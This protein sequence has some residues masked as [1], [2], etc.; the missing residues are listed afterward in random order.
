MRR[1]LA[2]AL[3]GMILVAGVGALGAETV[4]ARDGPAATPAD[5][6][7]ESSSLGGGDASDVLVE[8]LEQLGVPST[9]DT[10]DESDGASGSNATE[11]SDADPETGPPADGNDTAGALDSDGDGLTDERER[12]LGTEVFDPDTDGDGLVDGREIDLN[13]DPL[14]PDTDGDGVSDARELER[15]T[16]PRSVDADAD[17]LTDERELELGTDP[18]DPD[19]DDDGLDDRRELELGTD[20]TVADTDGDRLL[21]GWEFREETPSG[22]ALPDSDPLSM[23]LYVQVDYARGVE[24]A[25]PAFYD[26]VESEFAEMPVRGQTGTGI[27]VHLRGGGRVNETAVFTGE[28]F[29]DL[30]T[31]LYRD[32]LGPRAGTYHQVVV[33]DFA[34]DEVGYGSVGGRFALV[35]AGA[36]DRTQRHVVVHELLHNVVGRIDSS[37][38]CRDDP[39]H[40]CEGGWLTPAITPG[41]GEYLPGSLADEIEHQGFQP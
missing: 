26:Y 23:D 12:E 30:R 28:N 14:N 31:D 1:V 32:R 3:L 39:H 21:D 27:D 37:G 15:G 10:A 40:Y 41:E 8:K 25:S 4:D 33:T 5:E 19:T 24:T 13:T 6:S 35:D 29:G 2:M 38:A 11:D 20:P 16:S 34:S 17:G 22:A 36:A 18:F 9:G 7:N